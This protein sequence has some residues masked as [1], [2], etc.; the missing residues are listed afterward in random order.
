VFTGLLPAFRDCSFAKVA[1]RSPI[2][3]IVRRMI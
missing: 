3:P 2:R 1:R